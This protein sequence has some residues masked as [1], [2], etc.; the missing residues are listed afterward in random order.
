MTY[1]I[2]LWN[3]GIVVYHYRNVSPALRQEIEASASR[4][5]FGVTVESSQGTQ[6]CA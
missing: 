4:N 6:L 2:T 3:A 1:D 5:G